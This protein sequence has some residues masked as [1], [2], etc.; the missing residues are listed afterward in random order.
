M[1]SIL[2]TIKKCKNDKSFYKDLSLLVDIEESEAEYFINQITLFRMFSKNIETN[3]VNYFKDID[4]FRCELKETHRKQS[5]YRCLTIF[6]KYYMKGNIIYCKFIKDTILLTYLD[7]FKVFPDIEDY[8]YEL[9]I[10]DD[11]DDSWIA[12][13]RELFNYVNKNIIS[14]WLPF[15][16]EKTLLDRDV[17]YLNYIEIDDIYLLRELI[18]YSK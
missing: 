16:V 12:H 6:M 4:I 15:E 5:F 14:V 3:Y 2:T 8:K 11:D 1:N 7:F 18:K 9:I 10:H 17:N 13:A